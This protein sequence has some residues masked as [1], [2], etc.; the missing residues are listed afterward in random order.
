MSIYLSTRVIILRILLNIK[1]F[2]KVLYDRLMRMLGLKQILI[3]RMT[4]LRD[5]L[6]LKK[7]RKFRL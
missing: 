5:F 2:P 7:K 6:F 4:D 1:L 3:E